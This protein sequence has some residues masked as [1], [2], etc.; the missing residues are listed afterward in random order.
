MPLVPQ[1]LQQNPSLPSTSAPSSRIRRR[2][3]VS[4]SEVFFIPTSNNVREVGF[5]HLQ[6]LGQPIYYENRREDNEDD[7]DLIGLAALYDFE[8]VETFEKTDKT[9][10]TD[11]ADEATEATTAAI[12]INETNKTNAGNLNLDLLFKES[13]QVHNDFDPFKRLDRSPFLR[14]RRA[15]SM[16]YEPP[17]NL[18]TIIE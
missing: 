3:T 13:E 17:E 1:A 16:H 8:V 18:P 2:A 11:E 4:S 7:Q 14:K 15:T 9:D 6:H 5:D 10:G 12:A